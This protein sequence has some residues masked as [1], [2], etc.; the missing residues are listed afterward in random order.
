MIP[1][2]YSPLNE[3]QNEIRILSL[4]P[5]KFG[6][7][8]RGTLSTISVA[9]T[10]FPDYEAVSY[11]WGPNITLID[12][13][14][15]SPEEMSLAVTSNLASL[16]PY[17]RYE[18]RPRLLWI[19]AVCVNQK[20]LLERSSQVNRMSDI[21]SQAQRVVIWLGLEAEDT[22]LAIECISLISSKIIV[23]WG[24]ATM[25]AAT[26]EEDWVKL[27]VP[28]HFDDDQMM[29]LVHFF[30]SDW[31]ERLWVWQEV[32]LG[33]EATIALRGTKHILWDKIRDAVFFLC[34]KRWPQDLPAKYRKLHKYLS[35]CA[36]QLC[37]AKTEH[38]FLFLVRQ[39]TN[40][41]CSDPRDRVFALLALCKK[42]AKEMNIQVDYK[43][44][45]VDIYKDAVIRYIL[46]S[47]ILLFEDARPGN[48]LSG[49]PS[50]VPNWAVSNP[51]GEFNYHYPAMDSGATILLH[52][53]DVLE[54]LG[55][56]VACVKSI[57]P[58][59]STTK[60]SNSVRIAREL[61]DTL[62]PPQER[63]PESRLLRAFCLSLLAG[64]CAELW[65]PPNPLLF[66]MRHFGDL[67]ENLLQEGMSLPSSH[68]LSVFYEQISSIS[69]GRT[70]FITNE[71]QIGIGPPNMQV[72]DFVTVLLGSI[73]AHILRPRP[74][75]MYQLV[76]MAYCSGVMSGEAILGVYPNQVER[77][78][79]F[80]ESVGIYE[81]SFINRET[82]VLD[83]EDPRLDDLPKGWY[84]KSRTE[85]SRWK[86][87]HRDT[88]EVL[89]ADPR[90]TPEA[91]QSRGVRIKS[92]FLV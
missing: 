14:I 50:W 24:P 5:G 47:K 56:E 63:N 49:A 16:L 84:R 42:D 3:D 21:Y 44:Q 7:T 58:I 31:F 72:G 88:G 13:I 45:V 70:M 43:K 87:A 74:E 6:S 76:G 37:N 17:L 48:P 1:Y 40:C 79:V 19:D 9:D 34:W 59:G 52:P 80:N 33:S 23:D 78:Y 77:V 26:S 38:A 41:K 75:G 22:P 54:I 30:E 57:K 89:S 92:F 11:T 29:A 27:D 60:D 81:S 62:I 15:E 32:R 90:L 83:Q 73:S 46:S 61:V 82:G 85:Q 71:E 10:N 55:V 8:L 20:D 53:N 12:I 68:H 39:T 28:L 18:D 91:L 2:Q 36:Y 65:H 4:L 35:S 69:L 64:Q 25:K 86:F 67:V 66:S 51:C